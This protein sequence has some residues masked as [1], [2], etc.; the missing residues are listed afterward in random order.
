MLLSLL[1]YS[2]WY[3]E[4][5][6][7]GSLNDGSFFVAFHLNAQQFPGRKSGLKRNSRV[8]ALPPS[9]KLKTGLFIMKASLSAF[10]LILLSGDIS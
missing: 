6:Q 1:F 10:S 9:L 8:Q 7:K 5:T 4:N 3:Q 2:L